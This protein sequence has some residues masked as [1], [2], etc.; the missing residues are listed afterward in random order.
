MLLEGNENP[1]MEGDAA[2]ITVFVKVFKDPTGV[3]YRRM[4]V[5]AP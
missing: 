5:S 1:I 2:V 4:R 3:L